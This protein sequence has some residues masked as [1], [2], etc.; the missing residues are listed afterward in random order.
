MRLLLQ[1]ATTTILILIAATGISYAQRGLRA[2]DASNA[3]TQAKLYDES[4]A[5]VVGIS[6]YTDGWPKLANA[7]K[8]AQEIASELQNH[9]FSVDLLLDP[10][11][12]QLR[13][14]LD[15]LALEH[16]YEPN[17]R[18]LFYFAGHG[19]SLQL[20]FGATMGYIVPRDAPLPSK[21]RHSFRKKAI[22]MQFF[23]THAKRIESK[24]V[25]YVFDSCFAGSIFSMNRAPTEVISHKTSL[26]V[27]QFITAGAENETVP[28]KSIFKEQFIAA[29]R[30]QA[31]TSP[32][33][34]YVTGSELA[35]YIESRVINYGKKTQHPQFGKLR[36][37]NLDKGDFVFIVPPQSK[38]IKNSTTDLDTAGT[39]IENTPLARQTQL[40]NLLEADEVIS[41]FDTVT[42]DT[43]TIVF[44]PRLKDTFDIQITTDRMRLPIS[45]IYRSSAKILMPRSEQHQNIFVWVKNERKCGFDYKSN[46]KEQILFCYL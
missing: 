29:L 13:M 45:G 44:Q 17:N 34:G 14:A 9:G 40:E 37:P 35:L 31:D 19:M 23:E 11:E 6:E 1:S 12:V 8:D 20:Q 21:D 28:D 32:T 18:L 7:V 5:L 16:G 33:D 30:G 22:D 10:N 38:T 4:H 27:R 25:L 41:N 39:K 43:I 15:E 46:G 24:H 26:P 42:F 36:D 2:L 3:G